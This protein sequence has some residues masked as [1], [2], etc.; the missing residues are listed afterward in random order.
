MTFAG[1]FTTTCALTGFIIGLW[2]LPARKTPW[3]YTAFGLGFGLLGSYAF[4]RLQIYQYHNKMN[5]QFR[6]IIRDKY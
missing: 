4:W 1:F 2:L 6:S 3:K 5:E